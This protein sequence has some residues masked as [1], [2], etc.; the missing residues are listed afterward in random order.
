MGTTTFAL[1]CPSSTVGQKEVFHSSIYLL[2]TV[3][4]YG[5]RVYIK[6][7]DGQIRVVD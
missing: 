6:V 3:M 4:T 1:D 2:A 7:L 5:Q